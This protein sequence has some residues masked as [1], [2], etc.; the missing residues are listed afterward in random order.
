M[1][2]EQASAAREV[3]GR[4]DVYALGCVLFEMLA[5]EAPYTGPTPQAVIARALTESP[6]PL[7]P[8]RLAVPEAVDGVIAKAMARTAADRYAQRG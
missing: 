1:S 2:P 7:H 3:D 4:T 6:R 8:M 5:G